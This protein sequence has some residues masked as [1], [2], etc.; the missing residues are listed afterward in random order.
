MVSKIDELVDI[1]DV[2]KI[3]F[4][5]IPNIS[6]NMSMLNVD[7]EIHVAFRNST[8]IPYTNAAGKNSSIYVGKLIDKK[9][10][11]LK[12]INFHGYSV[13][14]WDRYNG[15]EDPRLFLWRGQR[16]C[17]FV[18]PNH[19]ITKIFMVMINLDT[20]E[21]H[22]L[23]DPDGRPFTKN[24]MPYVVDSRLY[25]VVDTSPFS[26]YEFEDGKLKLVKKD[27]GLGFPVFGG[28]P[29]VELNERLVAVVHGKKEDDEGKRTY[30]HSIATWDKDFNDMRI[31]K[32][33]IFE[34]EGIEFCLSM[35]IDNDITFAYSVHDNGVSVMTIDKESFG[36]LL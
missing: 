30:W 24:W 34:K 19:S 12:P 32:K 2:F 8:V 14:L 17:L 13:P 35:N 4:S 25:F 3:D 6:F 23:D 28:S 31:G 16:W 36:N 5:S 33:F 22:F 7:E 29:V 27:D 9:L 11:D 15:M 20:E 26:L 1:V 10:T 18:R 21:H